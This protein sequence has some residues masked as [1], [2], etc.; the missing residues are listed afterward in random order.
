MRRKRMTRRQSRSA[1]GAEITMIR[2]DM[3]VTS[4]FNWK[5]A[6][7]AG[8]GCQAA[9]VGCGSYGRDAGSCGVAASSVTAPTEG[10]RLRRLGAPTDGRRCARTGRLTRFELPQSS[11]DRCHVPPRSVAVLSRKAVEPDPS[12]SSPKDELKPF[13]KSNRRARWQVGPIGSAALI[14]DSVA[15]LIRQRPP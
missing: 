4:S 14:I 6:T 12:E 2:V 11:G 7:I 1:P 13:A 5:W 8:M 3:D 9:A 10:R 15:R